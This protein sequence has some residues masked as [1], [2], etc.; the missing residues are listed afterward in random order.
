MG[1]FLHKTRKIEKAQYFFFPP[2][3]PSFFLT[4]PFEAERKTKYRNLNVWSGYQT[5]NNNKNNNNKTTKKKKYYH[6]LHVMFTNK[7]W[8]Q[9]PFWYKMPV[10]RDKS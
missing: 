8:G 2:L 3:S 10:K 7:I 9:I 6:E 5:E 4:C 1:N